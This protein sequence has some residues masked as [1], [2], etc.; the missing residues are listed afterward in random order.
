[1]KQVADQRE[2]EALVERLV[3]VLYVHLSVHR[4]LAEV[5]ERKERA[6]V[7]LELEDLDRIV[8]EERALINRIG[9][10][11]A[12]RIEITRLIAALIDHKDPTAL[13]VSGIV[14][15]VSPEIG[16]TLIEIRDELR[17]VADR[18]QKVQ[19]RNRTLIGHSLDHI[20]LFLSVLSGV[21]PK[22]KHYSP[23]GEIE[24][25]AQPA[26]LDRRL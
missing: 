4:E 19:D 21:D 7:R 15:Y 2:I 14:P 12:E 24:K 10:T 5:L 17:N 8:E 3:D 16:T 23:H 9:E 26:V 22:L 20:H 25:T 13:R 18:I 11:E 1:M 6:V